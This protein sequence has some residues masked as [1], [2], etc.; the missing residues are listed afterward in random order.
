MP[1]R[2]TLAVAVG[3]A[4]V[5]AAGASLAS[6]Q[7]ISLVS[8]VGDTNLGSVEVGKS[9]TPLTITLSSTATTTGL[10]SLTNPGRIE[11]ADVAN[12]TLTPGTCAVGSELSTTKSCTNTVTFTPK[13]AGTKTVTFS[14][15]GFYMVAFQFS[16]GFQRSLTGPACAQAGTGAYTCEVSF[17]I[18]GTA[19]ATPTPTVGAA[20]TPAT[21][22]IRAGRTAQVT[23]T[24]S[25]TGQAAL[26]NVTTKLPIPSGFRVTNRGGGTLAGGTLTFTAA[27]VAVGASSTYKVTLRPIGLKAR[28]ATLTTTVSA[29]GATAATATGTITVRA[30]KVKKKP[31]PV[32]G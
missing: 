23:L 4:A 25:N 27:S 18:T 14:A 32:V 9:S 6:A 28:K 3:T 16:R 13:S 21:R 8:S 2:R 10:P 12:F 15:G 29:T 20:L 7:N 31:V 19:T 26:S 5:L 11:G 30:A 1:S 22:V 24:A 17:T